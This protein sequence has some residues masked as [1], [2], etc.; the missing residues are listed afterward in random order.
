M[1][2]KIFTLLFISYDSFMLCLFALYKY[3]NLIRQY[4]FV[5]TL[6]ILLYA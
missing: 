1:D 2:K 6:K 5:E 4:S 3:L